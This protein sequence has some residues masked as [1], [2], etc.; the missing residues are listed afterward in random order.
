MYILIDPTVSLTQ[1]SLEAEHKQDV[2]AAAKRIEQQFPANN[3]LFSV[4]V[5]SCAELIYLD[6]WGPLDVQQVAWLKSSPDISS[7]SW[8][9][10]GSLF[11]VQRI[12]TLNTFPRYFD[13]SDGTQVAHLNLTLGKG[14][15]FRYEDS[16]CGIND[17]A[18]VVP[19]DEV[20]HFLLRQVGI[21]L[22]GWTQTLWMCERCDQPKATESDSLC[23]TCEVAQEQ[24]IAG[25]YQYIQKPPSILVVGF[26]LSMLVLHSVLRGWQLNRASLVQKKRK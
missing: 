3:K 5:D 14:A 11:F 15:F 20:L 21:P 26:V 8:E 7:W 16:S 6:Q 10:G 1:G 17:V 4:S 24:F 2:V 23:R 18:T 25:S 19:S 22:S 13:Y 12:P 9:R